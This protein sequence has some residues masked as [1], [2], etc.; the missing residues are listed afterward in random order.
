MHVA[1]VFRS[2]YSRI[3]TGEKAENAF[4]S[5]GIQEFSLY[6]YIFFFRWSHWTQ[7]QL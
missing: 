4:R 3:V 5:T 7:L 1:G 2:A 6:M